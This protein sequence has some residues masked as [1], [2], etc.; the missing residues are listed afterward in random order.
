DGHDAFL[1]L[2]NEERDSA[3]I[4]ARLYERMVDSPRPSDSSEEAF[5]YWAKQ[6]FGD[7]KPVISIV[8]VLIHNE[9][10][11]SFFASKQIYASHYAEAGLSVVDMVPIVEEGRRRTVVAYT[12]RLQVDLFDGPGGFLSRRFA[13]ARLRAKLRDSLMEFREKLQS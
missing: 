9:P 13:Q 5:L 8:H 10:K 7:L 6:K 1:S 12:I 2:A 3:Q 4:S 11:H